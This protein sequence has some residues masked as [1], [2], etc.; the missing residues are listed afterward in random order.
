MDDDEFKR[1]LGDLSGE[2]TPDALLSGSLAWDV[3]RCVAPPALALLPLAAAGAMR[4]TRVRYVAGD[5]AVPDYRIWHWDGGQE[6]ATV[7]TEQDWYRHEVARFSGR[8]MSLMR[9]EPELWRAEQWVSQHNAAPSS[10]ASAWGVAARV[11][12]DAVPEVLRPTPAQHAGLLT[13]RAVI[14]TSPEG[15]ETGFR[16]VSEPHHGQSGIVVTIVDEATY[17]T[18]GSGADKPW[19]QL[20]RWPIDSVWVAP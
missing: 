12:D 2:V 8:P 19:G 9:A 10:E 15:A 20:A 4:G 6:K 16:A 11:T 13:G 18:L 14:L 5:Y 3:E 1:L 7:A 17:W